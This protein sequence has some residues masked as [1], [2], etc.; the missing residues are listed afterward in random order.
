MKIGNTISI[1]S[2]T[3]HDLDTI[4]ASTL[5]I[6]K[7]NNPGYGEYSLSD[8][9]SIGALPLDPHTYGCPTSQQEKKTSPPPQK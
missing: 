6:I 8:A 7:I 9:F 3:C 1:S 2:N 5:S 4:L